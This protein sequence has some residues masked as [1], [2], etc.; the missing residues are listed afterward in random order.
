MKKKKKTYFKY[1]FKNLDLFTCCIFRAKDI[2]I[3]Q[4]RSEIEKYKRILQREL[5]DLQFDLEKQRNE[6]K[7]E[8]DE[9]MRKREHEWRMQADE[10]GTQLMAKELQVH[11]EKKKHSSLNLQLLYCLF[12]L[13]VDLIVAQD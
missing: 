7:T 5:Q 3:N 10:F 9:V 13:C 1:R 2:E 8:F 4:E 11:F 12:V 6:L